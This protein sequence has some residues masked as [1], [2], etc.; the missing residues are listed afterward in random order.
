MDNPGYSVRF[1][2]RATKRQK[3]TTP[4]PIRVRVWISAKKQFLYISTPYTTTPNQW[5]YFGSDGTAYAGADPTT[6]RIVD[7][8]RAA[9]GLV[10][11]HCAAAGTIT[12]LSS[13]KL[14]RLVEGVLYMMSRRKVYNRAP[15][16]GTK[17]TD[18]ALCSG[19][20]FCADQCRAPWPFIPDEIEDAEGNVKPNVD[21]IPTMERE[22]TAAD[23]AA[24]LGFCMYRVVGGQWRPNNITWMEMAPGYEMKPELAAVI[25]K[26]NER[27]EV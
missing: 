27:E 7:T 25:T 21:N 10:L 12:D 6:I 4:A 9:V 5:A 8:Y 22:D 14:K 26:P 18:V 24:F 17:P 13:E 19:C 23:F 3:G 2:I 1:F 15:I 11:N 20:A 16:V